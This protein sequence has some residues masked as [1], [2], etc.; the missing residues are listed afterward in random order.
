MASVEQRIIDFV[1]Q[2]RAQHGLNQDIT[3]TQ[4]QL[5]LFVRDLQ[6]QLKE[7]SVLPSDPAGL[8]TF[9]PDA[10][11]I[12]YTGKVGDLLSWQLAE[13][14]SKSSNGKLFFISDTDAGRL[15]NSENFMKA[16]ATTAG[17]ANDAFGKAEMLRIFEGTWDANGIRSPYV[18]GNLV[19]LNDYVSYHMIVETATGEIRNLANRPS[20]GFR[21]TSSLCKSL[22]LLVRL[23]GIEP[24]TLGFGGQYSIH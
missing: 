16:V 22:I 4:A 19:S 7:V 9:A 21:Q 1:K 18:I 15:L 17:G 14:A 5:E 20:Y 6:A 24:T 23:A 13:A 10:K 8:R 12:P 2:W 11:P 3:L